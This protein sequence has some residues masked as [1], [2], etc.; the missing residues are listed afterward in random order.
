MQILFFCPRWGSED[1]PME[2]FL[3]KVK[4][5]GYDGVEMSLPLKAAERDKIISLLA[6]HRLLLIGQ[7]WECKLS[8]SSQYEADFARYL[9]NLAAARP[10][11]INSQTGKDY[12]SLER[13]LSLIRLADAIAAETGV[14]IVHETH[15]G[16][17][18]FSIN[19]MQPY[20]SQL[21]GLRLCADFSHWC[22]VSESLLQAPEQQAILS[23]VMSRVDHI[24]TRVGHDQSAQVSDPRAP[25]FEEAL[26]CHLRWWDQIAAQ[27]RAAGKP[28]LTLTPEFGPAPYM[29]LLPYTRQPIANQWEVN[30]HMMHLLRQR[31]TV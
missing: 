15:R 18:S 17:F 25:E 13:N 31:L 3:A 20:L 28:T 26:T 30:V 16:K 5:A 29:P 7:H 4:D 24:H 9:R 19:V 12:F 8:D 21:P 11:L 6:A 1:L 10:L 27:C 14:P 23:E 22:N 2:T